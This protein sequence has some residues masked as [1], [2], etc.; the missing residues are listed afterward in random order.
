MRSST[1]VVD[2]HF[3]AKAV[4]PHEI[5]ARDCIGS[6]MQDCEHED[7][8]NE[9][10]EHEEQVGG[11]GEDEGDAVE[12]SVGDY[13]DEDHDAGCDERDDHQVEQ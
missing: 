1:P 6:A 7:E 9:H 12:S 13:D 4:R 8:L 2:D 3:N 5:P 10:D 11:F